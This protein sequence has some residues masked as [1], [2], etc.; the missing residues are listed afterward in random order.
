MLL[1]AMAE[2]AVQLPSAITPEQSDHL[3]ALIQSAVGLVN[4]CAEL[5]GEAK[6]QLRALI[7]QNWHRAIVLTST[8][9]QELIA[10]MRA[11]IA[12]GQDE[13]V[14]RRHSLHAESLGKETTRG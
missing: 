9:S 13:E 5:D 8:P 14:P 7:G 3:T 2:A 1:P 11:I 6:A 12:L 10:T 4:S